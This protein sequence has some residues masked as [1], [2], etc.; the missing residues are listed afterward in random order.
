MGGKKNAVKI[1]SPL[2]AP[3]FFL[4]AYRWWLQVGHWS[5]N[6]Q[7]VAY[8]CGLLPCRGERVTYLHVTVVRFPR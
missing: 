3:E 8:K 2:L 4:V 1:Y 6:H 5:E 7:R